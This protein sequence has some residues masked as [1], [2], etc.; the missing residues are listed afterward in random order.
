MDG[1]TYLKP[2]LMNNHLDK[3]IEADG[4]LFPQYWQ[5]NTL[6]YGLK[7]RL[8]PSIASF[9]L[10]HDKV[11]MTRC[12]QSIAADAVPWTIID[13]NTPYAA[14]RVWDDMPLPFV[15]KI[16][17]SSM[18]DGV[19]LIENRSDWNRYLAKTPVIYAQEYLP[20]D[21]DLRIVWVGKQVV[22]GYW[23]IQAEQGFYNNVSKGGQAEMG[24][25][26]VEAVA[27]VERLALALDIDHGGF[28]IAM[29]GHR[30][31]VFEFNRIFGNKGMPGLQQK[32]D[33]AIET[34]LASI[35]TD[36]DEPG[37]VKPQRSG[38]G[39]SEAG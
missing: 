36:N 39:W 21:R 27:L 25:L 29:V 32:V 12:F 38:R 5:V 26:P 11:E 30:P 10:G 14:E 7:K 33:R 16:P 34:Y 37:P 2:D 22:G 28:D 19:Y 6:H 18:G 9:H 15:A 4:I 31:Y 13:A 23:R 24:I 8:F 3:I 17:R 20:I 35:W 1:I